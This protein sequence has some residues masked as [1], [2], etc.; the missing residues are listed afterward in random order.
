[1]TSDHHSYCFIQLVILF[2][3]DRCL[4]EAGGLRIDGEV[5]SLLKNGSDENVLLFHPFT[6]II[7]V[8]VYLM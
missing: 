2:R 3:V 6:F 4:C 8:H 7:H 5:M 1:M